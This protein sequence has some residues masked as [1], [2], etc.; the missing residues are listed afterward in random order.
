MNPLTFNPVIKSGPFVVRDF[1]FFP[2]P[3]DLGTVSSGRLTALLGDG[4]GIVRI[5]RPRPAAPDFVRIDLHTIRQAVRV[6]Y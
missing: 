2:N 5:P 6:G 1:V 4:S 3:F